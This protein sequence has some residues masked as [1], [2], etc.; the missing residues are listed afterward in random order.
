MTPLEVT[1]VGVGPNANQQAQQV[2]I[3]SRIVC[4]YQ[5]SYPQMQGQFLQPAQYC[6]QYYGQQQPQY[7]NSMRIMTIPAGGTW[8]PRSGWYSATNT[9]CTFATRSADNANLHHACQFSQVVLRIFL[10]PILKHHHRRIPLHDYKYILLLVCR[11]DSAMLRC[12][13]RAELPL[14]KY[15]EAIAPST[16]SDFRF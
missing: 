11:Q 13:S 2:H 7:M 10:N 16:D 14:F 4:R 1:L 5:Q 9:C 6:G 3:R 12:A 8:Q 15:L